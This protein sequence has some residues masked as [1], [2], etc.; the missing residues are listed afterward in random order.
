MY[1]STNT[2]FRFGDSSKR[3]KN[4]NNNNNSLYSS[5]DEHN[6]SDKG[7]YFIMSASVPNIRLSELD[8]WIL[9]KGVESITAHIKDVFMRKDGSILILTKNQIGSNA[10][11]RAI[12]IGT[13]DVICK[14]FISMNSC[15]GVIF[16]DQLINV[17]VDDMKENLKSENVIDVYKIMKRDEKNIQQPT[18]MAILTFNSQIVPENV[19]IGYLNVKVNPYISNPLRCKKCQ[20]FGHS[21]KKCFNKES[22]FL[23]GIVGEHEVCQ[24]IDCLVCN[25]T[26]DDESE[27][28]AKCIGFKC[29][30]CSGAHKSSDRRC[31]EYVKEYQ[32]S[33]IK[34]EERLSY[35]QAK[36]IYGERNKA[37]IL[38]FAGVLQSQSLEHS[39]RQTK[40]D[41]AIALL[42]QRLEEEIIKNNERDIQMERMRKEHKEQMKG[43]NNLL[44]EKDKIIFNLNK[45]IK[46]MENQNNSFESILGVSQIDQR[47]QSEL[48]N[49]DESEDDDLSTKHTPDYIANFA[50][51]N[52]LAL[53]Q[54]EDLNQHLSESQMTAEGMNEHQV[55]GSSSLSHTYNA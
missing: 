31:P 23:C 50:S 4:G 22:C 41:N 2:P 8:P 42:T 28:H 40:T 19:K 29:I 21:G 11:G 45:K 55:D 1:D 53:N 39:E 14:D 47:S 15:Q 48:N 32:I 34:C 38:D 5:F 12:K 25:N 44:Q 27:N 30:N 33:K 35:F 36:K 10:I 16:A 54:T 18:K 49:M 37:P 43:L 7:R 26:K 51:K 17:S 13:T 9:K 46:N 20:K 3:K 52:Y 24:S 6:C